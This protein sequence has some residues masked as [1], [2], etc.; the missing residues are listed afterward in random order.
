MSDYLTA[1]ADALAAA[2]KKLESSGDYQA[3]AKTLVE[4]ARGYAALELIS[5]GLVPPDPEW[6]TRYPFVVPPTQRP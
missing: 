3:S 2:K 4:V 5:R 1:A 6:N